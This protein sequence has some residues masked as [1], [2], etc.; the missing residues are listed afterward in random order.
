MKNTVLT[1][2][3]ILLVFTFTSCKDGKI[4]DSNSSTIVTNDSTLDS[5]KK[6][7]PS[8]N[9]L[10]TL[11][12]GEH[13]LN[14]ESNYEFVYDD[15]F[16]QNLKATQPLIVDAKYYNFSMPRDRAIIGLN[17][18]SYETNVNVDGAI[19]GILGGYENIPGVVLSNQ[20]IE[21]VSNNYGVT[22]KIGSGNIVFSTQSA[23]GEYRFLI[24]S[25]ENE[26]IMIQ[27]LFEHVG[28][29]SAEEFLTLLKSIKL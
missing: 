3:S 7:D 20:K 14:Y 2:L 23:V 22:A 12:L 17:Y 5:E 6:E 25:N 8:K 26:M 11:Q 19:D 29:K 18:S 21:D 10:K 16:T 28:L 1:F 4:T 24:L 9:K 15:I 27:G 13:Q